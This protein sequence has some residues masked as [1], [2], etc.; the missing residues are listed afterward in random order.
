MRRL[1]LLPAGTAL[2][3]LNVALRCDSRHA[4]YVDATSDAPVLL[5]HA[6]HSSDPLAVCND[7]SA[8]AYFAT[9]PTNGTTA[10]MI[11]L[12][13][14]GNQQM[15][16]CY[17]PPRT[18]WDTGT[19][20]LSDCYW[21]SPQARVSPPALNMTLPCGG[22]HCVFSSNCTTNPAFCTL[23][24]VVI[25]QCT[26]DN[27]LGDAT[28]QL[29]TKTH[30]H[31]A[32]YRGQRMLNATLTQVARDLMAPSSRVLVV[33]SDGGGNLLYIQADRIRAIV[34]T[35]LGV[36]APK[37]QYAVVP[38]EGFWVNWNGIFS[39][40]SLQQ[41]IVGRN[42]NRGSNTTEQCT[43]AKNESSCASMKG[44][45]KWSVSVNRTTGHPIVNATGSCSSA[46]DFQVP[47]GNA[48]EFMNM[49]GAINPSCRAAVD[50]SGTNSSEHWK[51]LLAEVA[52]RYIESRIYPIEQLWGVFGSFC[53]VNSEFVDCDTGYNCG[54]YG[55]VNSAGFTPGMK[56]HCDKGGRVRNH[57]D[58]PGSYHACVE[59]GYGCSEE[60]MITTVMP[61]Q[62]HV[63]KT[64][65]AMPFLRKPG[66]GAFMHS[67]HTGNED[68]LGA[69]FNSIRVLPSNQTAAQKLATWY[70]SSPKAP[71]QFEVPCL[72]NY[73]INP[74]RVYKNNCNPSCPNIPY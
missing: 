17:P 46:G 43:R 15:P 23:G 40:F 36:A 11:I 45:G 74:T 50:P 24:K 54:K 63:L 21:G 28:R 51:C 2:T 3:I 49:S 37:L 67:C 58:A 38:V 29:G 68:M 62:A 31:L 16:W 72:W 13:G 4:A 66:N 10:W 55:Y 35:A 7:G 25:P 59:Y 20:L 41:T 12:P 44:C 65:T 34:A 56:L 6:V 19:G 53:L 9:P 71:P 5:R 42:D 69:F 70:E 47:G 52:G 57:Q 1:V 8:P 64:F 73:S 33:G 61:Y 18:E 27:W 22:S 14:Q 48:W 30:P 26:F 39:G 60:Q 32:H